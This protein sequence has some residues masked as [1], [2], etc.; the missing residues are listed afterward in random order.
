MGPLG[1]WTKSLFINIFT[2]EKCQKRQI[3]TIICLC[4]HSDLSLSF[5]PAGLTELSIRPFVCVCP[6]N[7]FQSTSPSLI[8][9]CISDW[10]GRR[11]CCRKK[12][13]SSRR[14]IPTEIWEDKLFPG[15]GHS[16]LQRL[17]ILTAYCLQASTCSATRHRILATP[18]PKIC[19]LTV[20]LWWTGLWKPVH[21]VDRPGNSSVWFS[22]ST[23]SA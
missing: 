23:R 13:Q 7:F 5:F 8:S 20:W 2:E 6:S 11:V 3:E 17:K 10:W 19:R 12:N 21:C 22:G 4:F 18:I 9:S 14:I 15:F 1:I 16:R